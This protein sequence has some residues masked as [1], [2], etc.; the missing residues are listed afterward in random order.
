[1]NMQAEITVSSQELPK[2]GTTPARDMI[3]AALRNGFSDSQIAQALGIT[4]SAVSQAI[5]AH[6][7]RAIA[8]VNSKFA[9]HDTK[10]NDLESVVLDKLAA[11]LKFAVLDPLKLTAIYKTLNGAK[12]RSLAEGSNLPQSGMQ[13]VS[14][15][16]PRHV[17][18]KVGLNINNE[19][20]S[21]DGTALSTLSAGKLVELAGTKL[22][23]AISHVPNPVNIADIL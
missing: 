12:R 18:V 21:V 2:I 8:D 13:L 7:L 19:V 1:M 9:E 6:G 17:Q 23:G 22:K 20:I 4:Q 16:L 5:D 10:L 15:N 14:I 11:T 3:V